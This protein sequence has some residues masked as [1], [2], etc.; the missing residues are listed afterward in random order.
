ML[1]A[2]RQSDRV[3]WKA[4][5]IA[6]E[7]NWH[8]YGSRFSK[9]LHVMWYCNILLLYFKFSTDRIRNQWNMCFRCRRMCGYNIVICCTFTLCIFIDWEIHYYKLSP[10]RY[11]NA[12]DCGQ[13]CRLISLRL[14]RWL[15]LL[16]YIIY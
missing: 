8:W 5:K 2:P 7:L 15:S 13:N 11:Y 1:R 14:S 16:R 9:A 10:S 6:S 4:E 12:A 3:Q